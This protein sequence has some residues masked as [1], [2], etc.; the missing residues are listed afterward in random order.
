[1]PKSS[2]KKAP[3]EPPWGNPGPFPDTM[4]GQC[5]ETNMCADMAKI[6]ASE[7]LRFSLSGKRLQPR[8]IISLSS[9]EEDGTR[10]S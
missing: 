3:G 1:M 10:H 6:T 9:I 2:A 7:S 8:A 5:N 4:N